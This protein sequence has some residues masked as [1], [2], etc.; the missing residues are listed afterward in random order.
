MNLHRL[1]DD[2]RKVEEHIVQNEL[3][4]GGAEKHSFPLENFQEK[5]LAI[6]GHL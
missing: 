1:S 6:I 4:R 3:L 2:T 5:K